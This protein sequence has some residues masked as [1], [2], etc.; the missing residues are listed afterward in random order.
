M[1]SEFRVPLPQNAGP[2]MSATIPNFRAPKCKKFDDKKLIE[3]SER[4]VRLS[5]K[6][7]VTESAAK[8]VKKSKEQILAQERFMLTLYPRS[9]DSAKR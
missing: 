8:P 3:I 1:S 2:S 7:P 4:L 6:K 9:D 5:N